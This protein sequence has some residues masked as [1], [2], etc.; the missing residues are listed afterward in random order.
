[1]YFNHVH[2]KFCIMV[3]FLPSPPL[4]HLLCPTKSS[5]CC[6]YNCRCGA[7]AGAW[8]AT[9]GHTHRENRLFLPQKPT[10]VNSSS[11]SGAQA[12]LSSR[13][14]CCL[15]WSW[16]GLTG[17]HSLSMWQQWS[18]HVLKTCPWFLWPLA[19]VLFS[20]VVPEPCW[21]EQGWY[22]CGICGCVVWILISYMFLQCLKTCDPGTREAGLWV[23]D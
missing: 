22:K 19:P 3:F 12:P 14:E 17:R 4:F 15:A 23:W 6:P 10:S 7:S 2:T 16:V 8:F 18:C 11:T 20:S 5:L 9:Q 21:V 13:L 1:M